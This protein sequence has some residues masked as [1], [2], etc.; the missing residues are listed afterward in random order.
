MDVNKLKVG[1][2]VCFKY[3]VEQ[4]AKI[5]E[6]KRDWRGVEYVVRAFHGGYVDNINGTLINLQP[7]DCWVEE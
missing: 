3:D 2:T 7:R 1:D 4:S 5:I 6:V